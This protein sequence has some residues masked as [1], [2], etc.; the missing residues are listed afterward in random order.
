MLGEIIQTLRKKNLH[1]LTYI[2]NLKM[3]YTWKQNR[4]VISRGGKVKKMGEMLVKKYKVV[5]ILG[6]QV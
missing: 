2:W 6:K 4:M 5:F 3:S 1:N